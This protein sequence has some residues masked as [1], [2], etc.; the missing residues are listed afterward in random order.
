MDQL[1]ILSWN[2]NGIRAR[3]NGGYLDQVFDLDPD[4][5]CIQEVKAREDQL[6]KKL[7]EVEGYYTYFNSSDKLKGFAGVAIYSKNE[8]VSVEN[9]FGNFDYEDE[10]RILKA[11]FIDF[12][13]YNIY[14]P[15]GAG[16]KE[17]LEHKFNFYEHFLDEMEDMRDKNVLICGDFNIAH[18][19]VDLVDPRRAS[20]SAGF[21]PEERECLDRLLS[22]GFVDSFRMFESGGDNFSW[23]AYGRNCREKNLGMRS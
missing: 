17:G 20:K 23:W 8:P 7:K 6:P 18:N 21:L 15:S 12:I 9:S 2:V 1:K 22:L 5:L 19:E 16:S 11:D 13:L 14:F 10:G 4:I 3:H